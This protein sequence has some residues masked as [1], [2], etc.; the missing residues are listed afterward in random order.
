[1]DPNSDTW[2]RMAVG[3]PTDVTALFT[4]TSLQYENGKIADQSSGVYKHHVTF[5][6]AIKKVPMFATC[7]GQSASSDKLPT[8]TF[9]GASEEKGDTAFSTP[10]G[11]FNS[12][13]YVSKSETFTMTGEIINYTNDTKVIY[14]V[15]ELE[16]IPGRPA[17]SLDVVTQILSVNQCETS[18]LKLRPPGG[19]KIFSFKSKE[20]TVIQDG[21]I[22]SRRRL[23]LA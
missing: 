14:S 17:G 18:D 8:T 20:M 13:Y 4:N 12:G 1:M 6:T 16:Y 3:I 2:Y 5:S 19:Q 15:T 7:P 10:D 9:M 21:Y 22:L 23:L 11:K